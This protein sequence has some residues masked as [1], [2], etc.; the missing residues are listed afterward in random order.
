MAL[1]AKL[2][3]SVF[4][5]LRDSPSQP[6]EDPLVKLYWNRAGVKREL[7][8]LREERFELLEKIEEHERAMAK[9]RG[10]IA[11]PRF[12]VAIWSADEKRLESEPKYWKSREARV[13]AGKSET[14]ELLVQVSQ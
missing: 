11:A 4:G 13:A 1:V 9:V 7:R 10:E 6:A 12:Y 5:A 14:G 8:A 3:R 2:K